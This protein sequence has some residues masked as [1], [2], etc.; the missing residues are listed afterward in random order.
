MRRP[1]LATLIV[2]AAILTVAAVSTFRRPHEVIPWRSDLASATSESRQTG[3]PILVDFSATWCGPC[4]EMRRTTWS[5][6]RV[7]QALRGYI[8]V[9]IDLDANHDLADR[10]GVAAIPYLAIVDPNGSVVKSEEGTL[11][12]DE[13]IAWLGQNGP[14]SRP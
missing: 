8:P 6:T 4:Q 7:E 1:F 14:S 13:L 5:D 9:Q 3:K 2:I 11:S 12:A 10:Y